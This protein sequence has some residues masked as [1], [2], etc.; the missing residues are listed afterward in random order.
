MTKPPIC[1]RMSVLA[2]LLTAFSIPAYAQA[3]LCGDL[4]NHFGPF[5]YRSARP[6]DRNIVER[7]HFPP[8]VES[9]RKGNTSIT[10]GG[11]I[12]YTLSVFPNHHRALMAMMKLAK[13]EKKD[14]P[15]DSS[16]TVEC[17]LDR[18][19]RFQ[20]EDQMVKALYG[21]HLSEKRKKKEALAKLNE[22]LEL[23]APSPNIDYNI[24]LIFFDL[25][26]FEKSLQSAHRA[27]TGGF[28]L[29]G[30][31]NKLTRAGKWREPE[32][33]QPA[34]PSEPASEPP[35]DPASK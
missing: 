11:D 6:E 20:P 4:K 9:L 15:R 32:A 19:E 33:I 14:K 27:Y 21:I 34:L 10:P 16:Y 1:S 3:F 25:G 5:D 29:P 22:A 2:L 18:A 35:S 28:S 13:L 8:K 30:L 12:S 17:W 26:E 23:G 24:G 31:R 7:A